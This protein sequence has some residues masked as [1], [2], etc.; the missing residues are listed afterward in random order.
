MIRE[1][2]ICDI[3]KDAANIPVVI[4]G[5]ATIKINAADGHGDYSFEVKDGSSFDLCQKHKDEA[6]ALLRQMFG[7]PKAE[8]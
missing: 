6:F 4:D 5:N 2:T 7:K 3:C 1:I 8:K